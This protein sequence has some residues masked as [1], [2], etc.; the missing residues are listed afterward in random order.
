MR[1]TDTRRH[2]RVWLAAATWRS[3][4]VGELDDQRSALLDDWIARGRALVA[5]RRE[6]SA[7]ADAC[8]LAVALPLSAGRTRIA[9]TVDRKAVARVAA[10]LRLDEVIDRAPNDRRAA[11]AALHERSAAID[12]RLHVYGSYAWQTIAGEPCVTPSSDLDLLWD[13]RDAAHVE[14]MLALLSAWEIEHGLRADGEARFADG[15]AVAWRELYAQTS[16]VL[17]K[18]DD[19][20]ALESSPLSTMRIRQDDRRV[21]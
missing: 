6:P 16:R 9:L 8:F 18:R 14:R 2:D 5:R 21:A 12:T 7:T 3:H 15:A 17:V 1:S 19:A 4:L 13:A 20:V 10:P 11:L